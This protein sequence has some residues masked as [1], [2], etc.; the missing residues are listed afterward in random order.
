MN[1]LGTLLVHLDASP[2]AEIRLALARQLA[3]RC[4]TGSQG[5]SAIEA[6][7][8][9][10]AGSADAPLAFSEV[11]ASATALLQD[12]YDRRRAEAHRMFDRHRAESAA[13]MRWV[14]S[15]GKPAVE[16]VCGRALY[17]DLVFL[18]Q[19]SPDDVGAYGTPTDFAE[20]VLID[21]GKP[22]VVVPYAGNFASLGEKVLIAWKPC[23]EA[24]RAVCAAL[25]LLQRASRIH[26]ALE[27]GNH[28]AGEHLQA[29]LQAHGVEASLERHAALGRA[30]PGEALL[31][32][33]ADTDSDL[34]VM[35]CYG[36][37]R[38]REW[39]LGGVT[40]TVLASMTL[41]VL[42]AH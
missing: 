20:S 28:A 9:T 11:A 14:E 18:G 24:A 5:H 22:G 30:S 23:R 13:R 8:C 15:L 33:A 27:A 35:G 32:L 36:H 21:S 12:L 26:V 16:A 39:V 7:Y 17:A 40:R 4:G 34:L 41:P 38:A 25:P 31:S 1:T 19:H 29:W 6:I 42:M 10:T 3:N 37:S 2:R